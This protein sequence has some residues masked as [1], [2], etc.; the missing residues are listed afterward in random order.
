VT[1]LV[2][3]CFC[4]ALELVDLIGT[5]GGVA[6]EELLEVKVQL[7]MLTNQNKQSE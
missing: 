5:E 3:V 1:D 4:P 2:H 6:D 7:A